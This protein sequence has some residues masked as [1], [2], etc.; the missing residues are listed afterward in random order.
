MKPG[1][2]AKVKICGLNSEDAV[3]AAVE[4][5]ADW[6][7]FVFFPPSPRYV[8]PARAA[9]L[10]AGLPGGPPRVGLFVE[11]EDDAVATALGAVRLDVLQL[12]A[13]PAR[14]AALGARFGLPV[15]RAVGVGDAADL[16]R[17]AEGADGLLIEAKP[18]RGATRP[19]GNAASFD[20]SALGG[21]TPPAPWLLAGG[22][23]PANVAQAIACTGATAVDVSSG[24]ESSP[25]VKD[26]KLIRAFIDAAHG[27]K[28]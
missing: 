1:H 16:P 7:G 4:G 10:S 19:G 12:Y 22:L 2:T 11:P 18:P 14:V 9:A 27:I 8:T 13:S 21:W 17:S 15:W 5:G 3:Q 26:P 20:W 28:K 23:T 24:V 25:G 6:I